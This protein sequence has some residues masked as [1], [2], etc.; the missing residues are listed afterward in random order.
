MRTPTRTELL[1]IRGYIDAALQGNI[2]APEAAYS[3]LGTAI[4]H[5]NHHLWR[6]SLKAKEPD[7]S[8][9]PDVEVRKMVRAARKHLK[10]QAKESK[11]VAKATKARD[12][13][14]QWHDRLLKEMQD[15]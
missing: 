4:R 12:S 10:Q 15:G 3:I 6:E 13:D 1:V 2:Y 11:A 5:P 8:K 9:H 14:K 7:N